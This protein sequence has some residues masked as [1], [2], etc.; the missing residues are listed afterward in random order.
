MF[1]FT[2][3]T[4]FPEMFPGPLVLGISGRRLGKLFDVK[5][6]NIRDF[7]D[8]KRQTVDD[9]P[10]GGGAGMVMKPD[11]LHNAILHAL[12]FY[13]RK[14]YVF[15]TSPRGKQFSQKTAKNIV[16]DIETEGIVI[17][18]GRYEGIDERLIQYWKKNYDMMEISIGD[19]VLSGGEIPALVMIDACLRLLP[20]VLGN[21]E[22]IVEE[23]FSTDLLEYPHYTR[24][25]V[26]LGQEVP[27]V[28]LSGD[29]QKIAAWRLSMAKQIT[30][31]SR[32]DLWSKYCFINCEDV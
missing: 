25:A 26:W 11:V 8:D 2:V 32:P 10:Y 21:S 22:S 31:E 28:L 16:N 27:N 12:S 15:F 30:K 17:L 7:A 18:C 5:V 14:P 23:S 13:R 4:L 3:I 29:H 20:G 6:V 9:A 19:Y 24:P 1:L